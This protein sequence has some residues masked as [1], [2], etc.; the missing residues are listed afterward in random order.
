MGSDGSVTH[1]IRA[2]R[3]G[4]QAAAA[5]LWSRY[6]HRLQNVARPVLGSIRQA[7]DASDVALGAFHSFCS[8][9]KEGRFADLQ[10]RDE[11][12]RVLVVITRRRAVSWVR[13]ELAAMRG[14]GKVRGDA[15]LAEV[16]NQEPTPEFTAELLDEFRRLLDI[17]RQED[18]TLCLIAKRKSE[19]FSNREIAGEL[20]V[21][22]RTVER[23]FE[24]ICLVWAADV[25]KRFPEG[26]KL[27]RQ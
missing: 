24:R 26:E 25:D 15:L 18:V 19:G 3:Q 20:S 7:G 8:G 17:L 11:L 12:W 6:F 13:H 1:W 14:G 10:G 9:L 16:A 23:K 22:T 4:D 2:L 5:R 27:S 21:S